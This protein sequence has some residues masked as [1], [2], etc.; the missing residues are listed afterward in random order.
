ML[1]SQSEQWSMEDF[2]GVLSWC[3]AVLLSDAIALQDAPVRQRE[4]IG[5]SSRL[6]PDAC[7]RIL[8]SF[9]CWDSP[10]QCFDDATITTA[11]AANPFCLNPR[12]QESQLRK[13]A[14]SIRGERLQGIRR[15]IVGDRELQHRARK[16]C[17]PV[18]AAVD[19]HR[20]ISCARK[21]LSRGAE[22]HLLTRSHIW[23]Y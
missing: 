22:V 18:P 12:K 1:R 9:R 11:P 20:S 7:A 8:N 21:C 10:L 4:Q 17:K 2:F 5:S 6:D 23:G 3:C 13:E 16:V 19:P 15:G 14:R